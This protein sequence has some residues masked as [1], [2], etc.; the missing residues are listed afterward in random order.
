MLYF[1][2]C[3]FVIIS[4][5]LI[6]FPFSFN[7]LH[8]NYSSKEIR[9]SKYYFGA[10]GRSSDLSGTKKISVFQI[11][12]TSKKISGEKILSICLLHRLGNNNNTKVLIRQNFVQVSKQCTTF[13]LLN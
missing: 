5:F 7:P 3:P 8:K 9:F 12:L 13:F 10:V 1:I 4:K 6:Q 11:S 2:I